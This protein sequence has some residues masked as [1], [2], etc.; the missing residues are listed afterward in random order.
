MPIGV[1]INIFSCVAFLHEI[2]ISR[3]ISFFFKYDF[4]VNAARIIVYDE[5]SVGNNKTHCF[6]RASNL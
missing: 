2:L 6:D 1:A 5:Q 4:H 3:V